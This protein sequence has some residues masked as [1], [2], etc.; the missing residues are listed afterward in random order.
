MLGLVIAGLDLSLRPGRQSRTRVA[1]HTDGLS[2]LAN[3][4]EWIPGSSPG[5]TVECKVR[6]YLKAL[7]RHCR[8]CS[9]NPYR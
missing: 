1:I 2:D 8:T 4:T 9:G 6:T 3:V 7:N 5:M